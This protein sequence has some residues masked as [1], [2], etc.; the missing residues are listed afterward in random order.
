MFHGFI[1]WLLTQNRA[2]K[3]LDKEKL[4]KFWII[5]QEY[6]YS[7]WLLCDIIYKDGL[8]SLEIYRAKYGRMISSSR[9]ISLSEWNNNMNAIY[10]GLLRGFTHVHESYQTDS[11]NFVQNVLYKFG[12]SKEKIWVV[13]KFWLVLKVLD[14]ITLLIY[15]VALRQFCLWKSTSKLNPR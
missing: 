4:W 5:L 9:G 10:T 3:F 12:Y 14:L 15:W 8:V 7:T 11:F 13:F 2:F 1:F 6:G